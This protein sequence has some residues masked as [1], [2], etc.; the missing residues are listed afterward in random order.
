MRLVEQ[1]IEEDSGDFTLDAPTPERAAA[2]LLAAHDRARERG[3]NHVRLADGQS[4]RIEPDDVVRTRAFC[5][6]LD[7]SGQELREV[8]PDHGEEPAGESEHGGPAS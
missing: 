6:L 3:S 1:M 8:E 2:V 4:C 7:E 5:V